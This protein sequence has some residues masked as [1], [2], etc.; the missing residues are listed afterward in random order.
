MAEQHLHDLAGVP[1]DAVGLEHTY[2]DQ[3]EHGLAA[4]EYDPSTM[5]YVDGSGLAM[6]MDPSMAQHMGVPEE[7]LSE[8]HHHEQEL[9][10]SLAV[11]RGGMGKADKEKPTS[12]KLYRR[13][14]DLWTFDQL[15]AIVDFRRN[16]KMVEGKQFK[17]WSEGV[18]ET[19]RRYNCKRAGV[20]TRSDIR[21]FYKANQ[22]LIDA[23]VDQKAALSM[24]NPEVA[25]IVVTNERLV[26]LIELRLKESQ[27]IAGQKRK[28]SAMTSASGEGDDDE[29][30]TGEKRRRL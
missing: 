12:R 13:G 23:L 16:R 10:A 2:G 19:M 30:Y 26:E 27:P 29:D 21:A 3:G 25:R 24:E 9:A 7:H 22:N 20:Q 28:V 17:D 6:E 1:D 4:M 11:K 8:H 18:V 15:R 14:G 5:E